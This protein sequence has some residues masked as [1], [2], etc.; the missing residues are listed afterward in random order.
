[1]VLCL[2]LAVSSFFPFIFVFTFS[3][4]EQIAMDGHAQHSCCCGAIQL[5]VIAAER[6]K[7]KFLL[8]VVCFYSGLV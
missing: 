1:M 5:D 2:S 3:T 4:A 6:R 8:I 7:I